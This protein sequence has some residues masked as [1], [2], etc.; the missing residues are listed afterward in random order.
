MAEE[1]PTPQPEQPAF[2]PITSQEDLDR[3]IGHRLE[4]ERAKFSDYPDLQEKAKRLEEIE[5]ANKSEAEKAAERESAAT[6][7]AVEAEARAT[8]RDVALEHG[9]SKDDAAL[10]DNLTDEDA[11]KALAVRLADASERGKTNRVPGEGAN[12]K[13]KEDPMREYTR[14]LFTRT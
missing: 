1:T 14:A 5:A 11:M 3:R 9:L 10:L 12:P 8:R 13:S 4:R 2:E 7:R 6:K